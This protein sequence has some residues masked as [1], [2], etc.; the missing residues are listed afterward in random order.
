MLVVPRYLET[1]GVCTGALRA[2][3]FPAFFSRDSGCPAPCRFESEYHVAAAFRAQGQ[4]GLQQGMVLAV[5]IPREHE[6]QG[7]E[8]QGAIEQ[9]LREAD[10]RNVSGRDLT[11]FL[12]NRVAELSQGASLRSNVA[13]IKNNAVV[14]A[15]VA[16]HLAEMDP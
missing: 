13:L 4:L 15:R 12:L 7:A 10:A 11:P 3:T 8:V 1:K 6:A 14:A 5:P 16:G 2:D 9:A